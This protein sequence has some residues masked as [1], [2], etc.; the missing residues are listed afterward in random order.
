M[1][2][3]PS[4]VCDARAAL[5]PM[6]RGTQPPCPLQGN[7]NVEIVGT[8]VVFITPRPRR[9]TWRVTGGGCSMVLAI[10]PPACLVLFWARH[11]GG[12]FFLGNFRWAKC[13]VSP[14]QVGGRGRREAV[15]RQE[16]NVRPCRARNADCFPAPPCP[17]QVQFV[18]FVGIPMA[19]CTTRSLRSKICWG[20]NGSLHHN[21]SSELGS[22]DFV[23]V[24][25]VFCTTRFLQS[26]IHGIPGVSCTTRI[27]PRKGLWTLLEF[28]CSSAPQVSP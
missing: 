1:R 2:E 28:Q 22:V 25:V 6:R 4:F 9:E 19:F 10:M 16:R 20:S 27:I 7:G 5:P 18:E 11:R 26:R 17:S 12:G 8:L 24:P 15:T 23:W 13:Q 21:G 3:P 14:A